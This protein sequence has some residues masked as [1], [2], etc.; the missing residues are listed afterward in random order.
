[1]T[2]FVNRSV[3]V[4]PE[5]F[6]NK[7][8]GTWGSCGCGGKISYYSDFGVRCEKCSK[9]YGTW[10]EDLKKSQREEQK[11]KEHIA[12]LIE[13]KKFEDDMRI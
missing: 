10:V 5:T 6:K 1:M 3:V 9:L 7:D 11:R 8:Q 13:I 2:A 4:S 12:H